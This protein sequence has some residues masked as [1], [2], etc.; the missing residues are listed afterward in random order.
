MH[1]WPVTALMQIQGALPGYW[2]TQQGDLI[3][4][5]GVKFIHIFPTQS[6]TAAPEHID[7]EV[8][9][10]F[11]QSENARKRG[12]RHIAGMGFRK[13]L[14][15]A[16]KFFDDTVKGNL[17]NRIDI[18]ASRHDITP[19]M[20]SWAHQVRLIRNDA[21]HDA[22]EPSSDDIDAMSGFTE[23][24]LKYLFTLPAEVKARTTPPA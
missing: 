18:L 19:A 8:A 23:T 3:D 17:Y 12:D 21:A 20:K 16:L 6:I 24:L 2:I 7:P 9:N 10:I 13:T 5:R 15:I 4:G 22:D 1:T 11:V 14:D